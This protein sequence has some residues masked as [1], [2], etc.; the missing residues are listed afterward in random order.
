MDEKSIGA[1]LKE[2]RAERSLAE[3]A[4]KVGITASALSN[5]EQGLRIPRDSIKRK[6]ADYFNVGIEDL[7]F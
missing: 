4:D 7:F 3:V 1:K 6:L 5:Y 2:L